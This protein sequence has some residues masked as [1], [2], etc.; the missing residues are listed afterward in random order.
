MTAAEVAALWPIWR[1]SSRPTVNVGGQTGN[2]YYRCENQRIASNYELRG[3]RWLYTKKCRLG[4]K[5]LDK[6]HIT[7]LNF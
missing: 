6:I 3:R 1:V 7:I 5:A 4:G 2:Y